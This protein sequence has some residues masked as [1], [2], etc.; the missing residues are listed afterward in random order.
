[1]SRT[2]EGWTCTA[3]QSDEEESGGRI[4]GRNRWTA[5]LD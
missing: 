2:R 3:M 1:M 4:R 5:A